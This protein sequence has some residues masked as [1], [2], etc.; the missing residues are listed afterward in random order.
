[1]DVDI[2]WMWIWCKEGAQRE[3]RNSLRLVIAPRLPCPC[4]VRVGGPDAMNCVPPVLACVPGL[5]VM[6]C[7]SVVFTEFVIRFTVM[8]RILVRLSA[9]IGLIHRKLH[10]SHALRRNF[11]LPF[12]MGRC[13]LSAKFPRKKAFVGMR[14]GVDRQLAWW[15]VLPA[16]IIEGSA[17]PEIKKVGMSSGP[18]NTPPP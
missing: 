16:I 18:H 9:V 8:L 7:S 4:R 11:R 6:V 1:M 13:I 3:G 2:K 15:R 12:P 10:R 17:A 5:F 14:A